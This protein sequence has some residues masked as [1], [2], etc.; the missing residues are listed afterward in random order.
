MEQWHLQKRISGIRRMYR[1]KSISVVVPAYNEELLIG[2]TLLSVPEYVDKIYAVDDGSKDRTAE[3]IEEHAR[4][5]QR[6]IFIKHDQNQGVGAAI[7]NGYRWSLGDGMDIT[8]VMAG[9]NQMDPEYLPDLLD[10]IVENRADYTKGNRLMSAELMKGMSRW[11]SFGNML[12]TLLTKI[13]SGYWDLVDPQN[14]YTAISKNVLEQNDL[15]SIYTGYG[16]CNNILV[17]LNIHGRRVQDVEIPARYGD[18]KS[19]IRYSTYIPRLSGLLLHN[20]FWRLKMKYVVMSFHPLILF[21]I[22][23]MILLLL[24]AAGGLVTLWEKL[25]MGYPVFFVHG[26]LSLLIFI[27]GVQSVFFAMMFDLE[28]GRRGG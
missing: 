4:A 7:I 17:W 8:A 21:Y 13:A 1:D 25:V 15:D 24:G 14:G 16:Y 28:S 11:R 18:E 19:G 3:I 10:P 22:G 9:D 20:F 27:I 5:D 26:C 6:I 23:G 2:K 12:L